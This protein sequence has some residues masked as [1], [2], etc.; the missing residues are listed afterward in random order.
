MAQI[1]IYILVTIA[2]IFAA[3]L[4]IK[5]GGHPQGLFHLFF[6]EMW[7]RF[8]FYG[9]RALLVLYIIKDY[10][11]HVENNEEIAYG[12]YAAYGALVYA[13]PL[14]GGLIADKF[15][16]FRKAILLGGILMAIGHF[17]MAFPTD[18]F[19]YGAL[20]LLIAGNGF[21]KPNISSLVGALY[22]TNDIK[23][24][25]GFTIFYMG[26]N[27]GAWLAPLL[28]GYLGA[29]YGWH[30]GF[31]LA[32]IG[33][34]A[35]VIVFWD[36]IKKGVFGKEGL[37]PKEYK[38][39]KFGLGSIWVQEGQT[40]EPAIKF[41]IER[42]VYFF[43]FLIVPL[44]AYLIILEAGG[45]NFLGVL[46]NVLV[47]IAVGYT[48]LLISQEI[49]KGNS[50]GAGKLGAILILAV[51][52]AIF[53]ACF[54]QAGSSIIVWTDKCINLGFFADATMTNAINPFYIILLAIPF[55][56]LWSKLSILRRNPNTPIKFALGLAFLGLGF[57]TFAYSINFIN[58]AG[59]LPLSTLFIGFLLIT[60]G[61]LCLSPIGLSKVTQ[62]SPPKLVGFF[63]GL[64]FL[65]STVAHYISGML[66][67]LTTVE[68]AQTTGVLDKLNNIL[69]KSVDMSGNGV[70]ESMIYN[71]LFGKIGFVTIAIA[72]ITVIL[73]PII[74]KLMHDVH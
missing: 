8:S 4:S 70:A 22:K 69:F 36:G 73:S 37:Q 40:W 39:K 44:F 61:E 16:G 28:C 13:T 19:F 50:A 6:A 33:M 29:K 62:L 23:R 25:G 26:I 58:D 57:L 21:F 68:T 49:K 56:M 43:A 35:G 74:K 65:S 34:L 18:F 3:K 59:K 11:A 54:E 38:N 27:L 67:K 1:I 32:G 45:N 71:D 66:A 72:L 2:I 51:L 42:L 31:G 7:E 60:T 14:L 64:W 52:C 53:W 30:Y 5:K 47:A 63:M 9:M 55:S 46:I 41:T 17:F 12:I 20:G 15:I 10:M 24:D 48:L